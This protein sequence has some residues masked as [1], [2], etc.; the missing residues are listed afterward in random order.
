MPLDQFHIKAHA[1]RGARRHPQQFGRR[2]D[3]DH[4]F[5]LVGVD[6]E[7]DAGTDANFEHPSLRPWNRTTA[8][9]SQL[10]LP[11]CHVG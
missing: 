4:A 10:P 9:R 6:R 5:D 3:A 1:A 7:I 11:H 2:I 8:I